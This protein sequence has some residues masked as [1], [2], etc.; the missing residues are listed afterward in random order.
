MS[1]IDSVDHR[2]FPRFWPSAGAGLKHQHAR[3]ILQTALPIGFFEIHA[4]SYMGAGGPPH[5]LLMKIRADY[6]LCIHGVGLSIGT[7]LPLDKD[8][9]ARLKRLIDRYQPA[10]FSEHLAWSSHGGGV[11]KDLLPIPSNTQTLGHISDPIATG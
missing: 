4:E 5:D 1:V 7:A 2:S 9:L 11:L 10:L 8:H 3:D 6:P